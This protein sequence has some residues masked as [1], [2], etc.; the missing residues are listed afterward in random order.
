LPLTIP[1]PEFTP[2]PMKDGPCHTV[3]AF[4]SVELGENAPS[5]VL[6]INVGNMYRV[7]GMRPKAPIARASVDGRLLL[8]PIARASVDGRLLLRIERMSSDAL[9]LPC[10]SDPATRNRSSQLCLISLVFTRERAME[11]KTP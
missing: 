1:L 2:L 11:F 7:R 8:T 4:T 6:I 5:I 10:W 3:T 9:T